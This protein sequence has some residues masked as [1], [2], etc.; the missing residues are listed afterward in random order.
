MARPIGEIKDSY[1][2]FK[3]AF[4][5]AIATSKLENFVAMVI[6]I[7]LG[8]AGNSLGWPAELEEEKSTNFH[9]LLHN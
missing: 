6:I 1:Y 3:A 8:I 5:M 7:I 9:F 4:V 2:N